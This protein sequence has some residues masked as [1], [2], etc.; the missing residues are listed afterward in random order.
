[1][2]RVGTNTLITGLL[3]ATSTLAFV[4]SS[5]SSAQIGSAFVVSWTPGSGDPTEL[6]IALAQT[7]RD[8]SVSV[9]SNVRSDGRVITITLP[10]VDPGDYSL[11]F[12]DVE[13]IKHVFASNSIQVGDG[14]SNDPPPTK[15]TS[16]P[17]S[18]SSSPATPTRSDTSTL[19][20]TSSTLSVTPSLTSQSPLGTPTTAKPITSSSSKSLHPGDIV[21]ITFGVAATLILG[22]FA[23]FCRRRVR[24][25]RQTISDVETSPITTESAD[26]KAQSPFR[27]DLSLQLHTLQRQ[28][29]ELQG[30]VGHSSNQNE[31]LQARIRF[32]EGELESQ[33]SE[34]SSYQP[35]PGYME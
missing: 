25:K 19:P 7:I 29:E 8:F 23:I 10:Q 15:S 16:T 26:E 3:G 1:M 17:A 4:I 9:A 5:P 20:A 27:E 28:L 32:L 33:M 14:T 24:R 6:S 31:I 30:A 2:V 35:P 18:S 12:V 21:G 34:G 22:I 13:D 11:Q